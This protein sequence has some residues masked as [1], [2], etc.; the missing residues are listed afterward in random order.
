MKFGGTSMGSAERIEAAACLTT[1]QHA[2]RP[3]AIVV[4]A[5]SKVTDLLLDSMKKAEAGDEAGLE[6]NLAT[7]TEKHEACCRHL[8]PA[9]AQKAAL[10]G[11]Q[12]LIAEFSKIVQGMLL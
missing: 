7:L 11:V 4:S 8:L 9:S 10:D 5:M 2:K 6:A 12:A 3:V 1:E